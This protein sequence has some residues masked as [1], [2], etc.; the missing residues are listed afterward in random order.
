M[1]KK[2]VKESNNSHNHSNSS[3]HNS[4]KEEHHT[5]KND[6]SRSTTTC[7][8]C[9]CCCCCRRRRRRRRGQV[10]DGAF[11]WHRRAK[12]MLITALLGFRWA[13]SV[14]LVIFG[15]ISGRYVREF[16]GIVRD[17]MLSCERSQWWQATSP[18]FP[19]F[20]TTENLR[21]HG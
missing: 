8:C 14:A 20:P 11:S 19:A 7:C 12:V 3:S 5:N 10:R 9:C 16:P 15:A 13:Q 17:E 1:V 4:D 21:K 18:L 2:Q 6:C